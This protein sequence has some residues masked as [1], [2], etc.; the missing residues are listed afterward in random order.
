MFF[1]TVLNSDLWKQKIKASQYWTLVYAS[2]IV[3]VYGAASETITIEGYYGS[4]TTGTDGS[5]SHVVPIDTITLTGSVSRKSFE[6]TVT[7]ETTKVYAMPEGAL[8]WYGNECINLTGGWQYRYISDQLT[9]SAGVKNSDNLEVQGSTNVV[10]SLTTV[11][12]MSLNGYSKIYAYAYGESAD[13]GSTYLVQGSGVI[14]PSLFAIIQG[15]NTHE[16]DISSKNDSYSIY[17]A[18]W[19]HSYVHAKYYAIWLE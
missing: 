19:Q 15:Y 11:N 9:T 12:E 13:N 2:K 7:N 5:C 1:D 14:S 17:I 8:Y 6:R 16:A 3:T 4:F 10:R 18:A